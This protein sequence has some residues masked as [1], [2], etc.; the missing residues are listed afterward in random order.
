M[1]QRKHIIIMIRESE[2]TL[3]KLS[4]LRAKCTNANLIRKKLPKKKT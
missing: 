2:N 1:E 4:R 3:S